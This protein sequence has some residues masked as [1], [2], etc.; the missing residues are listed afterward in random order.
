MR[1]CS[2]LGHRVE[3]GKWLTALLASDF[4]A[5]FSSV[6]TAACPLPFPFP[7][8]LKSAS[9]RRAAHELGLEADCHARW[10]HTVEMF[11]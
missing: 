10:E 1:T 3:G 7:L 11:F 6:N 4:R 2:D 9:C 8:D 5:V